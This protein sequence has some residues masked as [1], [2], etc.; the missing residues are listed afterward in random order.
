MPEQQYGFSHHCSFEDESICGY[1][2][3]VVNGSSNWQRVNLTADTNLTNFPLTD[4]TYGKAGKGL[5]SVQ[6]SVIKIRSEFRL[7]GSR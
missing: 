1:T 2:R 5:E 6:F 4:A 3:Q 7:R